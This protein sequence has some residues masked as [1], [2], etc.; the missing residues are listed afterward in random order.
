MYDTQIVICRRTSSTLKITRLVVVCLPNIWNLLKIQLNKWENN[1]RPIFGPRD[2][3]KVDLNLSLRSNN[4]PLIFFWGNYIL[5]DEKYIVHIYYID[6]KDL[7]MTPYS[8]V[9]HMINISREKIWEILLD[10]AIKQCLRKLLGFIN[11]TELY[12]IYNVKRSNNKTRYF[13]LFFIFA[14]L[15]YIN[16]SRKYIAAFIFLY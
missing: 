16:S 3:N 8:Y 1:K 6:K 9:K 4:F 10:I 11:K 14:I 13:D 15:N 5:Y 2:I 7:P 12:L